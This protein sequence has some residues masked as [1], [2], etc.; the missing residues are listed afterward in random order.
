MREVNFIPRFRSFHRTTS[1]H[2]YRAALAAQ[3]RIAN[4]VL[5]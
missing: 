4:D 1:T 5:A 3:N 2:E